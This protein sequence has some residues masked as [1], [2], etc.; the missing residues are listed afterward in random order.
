MQL[1]IAV[2]GP[3]DQYRE[4]GVGVDSVEPDQDALRL[5]YGRL[6]AEST[7]QPLE[8]LREYGCILGLSGLSATFLGPGL[9]VTACGG[10]ATIV[11]QALPSAVARQHGVPV[12]RQGC[13][14]RVHGFTAFCWKA[15]GLGPEMLD[16]WYCGVSRA[17]PVMPALRL[18]SNLMLCKTRV[19]CIAVAS[20]PTRW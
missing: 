16:G 1:G 15:G 12:M 4:G 13:A 14:V 6:S 10:C 7:T 17:D 20:M 19:A 11:A 8:L 5:L 3:A 18:R 2:L 9:C